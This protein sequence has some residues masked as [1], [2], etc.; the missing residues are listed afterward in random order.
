M[1]SVNPAEAIVLSLGCDCLNLYSIWLRRFRQS[2]LRFRAFLSQ[3]RDESRR[4][5]ERVEVSTPL[6]SVGRGCG[7]YI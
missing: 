3:V 2:V 1:A 7:A 5:R 6:C 4:S